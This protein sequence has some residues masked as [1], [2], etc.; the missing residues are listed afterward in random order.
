VIEVSA[1]GP[2]SSVQDPIGRRGWRR[3]GVPAGGAADAWSGR[4]ANRLA[5]ND[6][7][8]A[9]IE[10]T[11]GGASFMT[12]A[13]ATVALTGG[14]HLRIDGRT[15]P[16]NQAM[17]IPAGSRIEVEPG[18]RARGYLAVAGGFV[19]PAV[20]DGA[21]TDLR[22]GFGGHEGRALQAGDRL[23][24][25][26]A[27]ARATARWT[28]I[29]ATGPI[30]VLRGPYPAAFEAL[31][32]AAWTVAAEADRAGVRLDGPRLVGGEVAS[33][34]LPIGAIQV[35]PD[36]RPI[37]MLADRPVTGGYDV[38]AC[39]IRADIGRVAQLRTGDA[40]TFALVD[41]DEARAA[42]IEAE[43]QLGLIEPLDDASL[44]WAGAHG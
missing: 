15:V 43:R 11:L 25:G 8:A 16:T 29:R 7:A 40:V 23:E 5:G 31:A 34:G 18:D 9:I 3:Y 38:A 20:L 21:S 24:V 4:L 12:D 10:V 28:G 30:R 1:A 35:P 44:G 32:S 13:P 17:R 37:V 39:V 26:E 14:L 36:G 41:R 27:G 6:E 2:L 42:T 22:S 19:V 33:L